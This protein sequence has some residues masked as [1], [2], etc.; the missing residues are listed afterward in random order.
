MASVLATIQWFLQAP[1]QSMPKFNEQGIPLEPALQ[2][3]P[4]RSEPWPM[5]DKIMVYSKFTQNFAM[6]QSV[7][8]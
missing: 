5:M 4:Y 2:D 8:L 3:L 6:I 7:C 1:C